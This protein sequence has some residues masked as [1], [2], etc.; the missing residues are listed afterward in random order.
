MLVRAVVEIES[1]GRPRV[2]SE[3]GAVG[4]MQITPI[5][6]KD[7]LNR[8]PDFARGDLTDPAYNLLIGTTYLQQMLQRFDGDLKLA[9]AAYHMGPTAVAKGRREHPQ[10]DTDALIRQIAGPKTRAY[11]TNVLREAGELQF[12]PEAGPEP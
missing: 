3:R 4:L 9:L 5:T 2:R 8:N 7:V 1:G 11:V 6:E 12:N 10:L